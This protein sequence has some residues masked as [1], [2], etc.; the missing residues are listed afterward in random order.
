MVGKRGDLIYFQVFLWGVFFQLLLGCGSR[1]SIDTPTSGKLNANGIQPVDDVEVDEGKSLAIVLRLKTAALTNDTISWSI[2]EDG[3]NGT[4]ARDDF[5]AASGTINLNKGEKEI[6]L[7]LNA[8]DDAKSDGDQNYKV[9]VTLGNLTPIYFS[10]TKVDDDPPPKPKTVALVG[11]GA[12]TLCLLVNGTPRCWGRNRLRQ[13]G[14][15]TKTDQPRPTKIQ[16]SQGVSQIYPGGLT[17]CAVHEGEVYCWGLNNFGQATGRASDGTI[18]SGPQNVR[19]LF[20]V[21]SSNEVAKVTVGYG[22]SCAISKGGALWCWGSN[23]YGGRGIGKVSPV[24]DAT[25]VSSMSSKVIDVAI[26]EMGR[27]GAN[28]CAIQ[29][30]SNDSSGVYCW[31]RN[32]HGQLGQGDTTDRLTPKPISSL[33]SG[34]TAIGVGLGFACAVKDNGVYCW[35]RNGNGNLGQKNLKQYTT[36]QRVKRGDS[37]W[38]ADD[39]AI[40]KLAVGAASVCVLGKKS[41]QPSKVFCWGNNQNG[42]LGT[43]SSNRFLTEPLEVANLSG[44]SDIALGSFYSASEKRFK[45]SILAII[46]NKVKGVGYNEQGQL[47]NDSTASI[48]VPSYL[49]DFSSW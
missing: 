21:G 39:F 35:G 47:G 31:G 5:E 19:N 28:V 4:I 3:P 22:L 24:P 14:D 43:V 26:S 6:S 23:K 36:P 42:Y 40:K 33:S 45:P 9:I 20:A 13:L 34:V 32:S 49:F 46:G 11:G 15:F 44:A 29:K 12:G 8:R 1:T 41:N 17:T 2:V 37:P 25:P 38:P 48:I 10:L 18:T 30:D 27:A 7:N 16:L